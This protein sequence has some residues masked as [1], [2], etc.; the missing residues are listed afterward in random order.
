M[1]GDVT[2]KVKELMVPPPPGTPYSVALPGSEREGRSKVYRHW[3][4]QDAL[5][6][7]LDPEIRTVHDMFEATANRLPSNKCL[8][9]RPYDP[10]S[11]TFGDYIWIDYKTVQQRRNDVGAGFVELHRRAGVTGDKYG[12]GLWCQNRPE[13]QI[14][15]IACM[16]QSLFT[17]SIYD[18]LGPDVA[19]Y[20]I[21][22]ASLVC[23]VTSLPHI[24]SLLKLK[25]KCP[26][27][28]FIVSVDPL[29]EGEL[30]GQSK[31][32]LLGAWAAEAGVEIHSLDAIEDL[33]RAFPHPLVPPQPNDVVTINY[34]SGTT[35]N[36]KGVVLT[37]SNAIAATSSGR[38]TIPQD[39]K[40]VVCSYLPLAHIYERVGLHNSLWAGAAI[41]FFHGNILE[42][43]DD[44]KLLRPTKFLSVP[45]LYNR[46]GSGLRAA[47]VE[48]SGFKGALSR[49]IVSTKLT[50]LK[51][52]GTNT[53]AIYDRIWS[54]KVASALGLER[55]TCMVSGSAPLD[56]NLHQFLR[57]V[58][59]NH[60]IQGYGLTES[61]AVGLAQQPGDLSA[62]NCGAVAPCM[63]ACLMDVP[64]MEYLHTDIPHAR[65][66]L[67]LRGPSIFREY[68]RNEQ[69]TSK[70]ILEDGGWFRTGD[71]CSVDEIGRFTVIDRVK[72]VLK[73]A[74]GEY[75]SPERIENVL[76]ANC[77]WLAQAFVYG[78]SRKSYL[79]A[80]LGVNPDIFG[81]F[82]EKVLGEEKILSAQ[83][84]QK[85]L[86]GGSERLKIA[87]KDNRVRRAVLKELEKVATRNRFNSYEKI[88]NVALYLEPF[89]VENGLLT[90]TLK[91]KRPQ[92]AKMFAEDLK[93]LYEESESGSSSSSSSWD[94]T[95]SG[96]N[97]TGVDE[98]V[99]AKL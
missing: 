11:K 38:L 50:N 69:E 43:L 77:S 40:D 80:V 63:E 47:T 5:L 23:V 17:V 61:Y 57:I 97:G 73:L 2:A 98:M 84:D 75:V 15:D 45:R 49:H 9:H 99:K 55:V 88:R 71:I 3:R 65:G 31:L 96:S 60:F 13:W 28:R 87:L 19:E 25:S 70:A 22:H 68:F 81:A 34:T 72:N 86:V 79:V 1:A 94:S 82:V 59:S 14:T 6:E 46:F 18:T 67:L 41:G 48:A 10:V 29:D 58:F 62:G 36:P 35:G 53:H 26:T 42:L 24:P 91:L 54:R 51:T 89:T 16:S 21:N 90:P 93:R 4:F 12:I 66:E 74:Q 37:H 92:T 78:D 30:P 85:V 56:P 33:G 52:S 8:G 27:L 64:D 95:G 44:L 76:L 20:I 7:T 39:D 32:A 83:G